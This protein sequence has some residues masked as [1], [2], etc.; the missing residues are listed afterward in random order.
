[1]IAINHLMH[2]SLA[3]SGQYAAIL[4]G[5]EVTVPQLQKDLFYVAIEGKELLGFYSLIKENSELDL[6]FVAD[7]AQGKGI[8][9]LL[10]NHLSELMQTLNME[11]LKI[12]SHPPALEFYKRMGVQQ[13][14]WMEPKGKVTWKRPILK[15]SPRPI[16][17]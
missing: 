12:V 9:K 16:P 11:T 14:G 6:L 7:T 4:D 13:T 15:Y 5:Y 8:G 1:L 3:Y 17:K 10:F 2:S